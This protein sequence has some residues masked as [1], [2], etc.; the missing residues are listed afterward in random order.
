M[1]RRDSSPREKL[2]GRRNELLYPYMRPLHF[3]L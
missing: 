2:R 1:E 3:Y